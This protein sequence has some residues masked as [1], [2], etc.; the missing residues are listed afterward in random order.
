MAINISQFISTIGFAFLSGRKHT[1]ILSSF[2][3]ITDRKYYAFCLVVENKKSLIFMGNVNETVTMMR[4]VFTESR[5]ST[6]VC[7]ALCIL[8]VWFQI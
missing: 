1:G 3:I 7:Q 2:K 8:H 4:F 6:D 5:F